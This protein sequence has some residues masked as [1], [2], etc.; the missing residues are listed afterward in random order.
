[1]VP[2]DADKDACACCSEPKP[3][4]KPSQKSE[5]TASKLNDVGSITSSGFKFGATPSTDSS[6]SG[7]T[8]G[9]SGTTSSG[10]TLGTKAETTTPVTKSNDDKKEYS[11]EYLSHLKA[12]NTQ[13]CQWIKTHVEKNPYVFLTPVFKDYEK[14]LKDLEERNQNDNVA[15]PSTTPNKP[16]LGGVFASSKTEKTPPPPVQFGSGSGG[17]AFGAGNV[18]TSAAASAT[19]GSSGG[20]GFTFGKSDDEPDKSLK[21]T[22]FSFGTST[23]T[24]STTS[25]T[26]SFSFGS[27]SSESSGF[28]FGS[29]PAAAAATTG[30]SFGSSSSSGFSFGSSVA[31]ASSAGS[32]E[33]KNAQDEEETNDEPPKVEVKEVV[34]EDAFH[35]VR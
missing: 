10:F 24:A 13:V 8:F 6:S 32:A 17:F 4:A 14:H 3:G 15:S 7:F 18:A 35:S 26:S 1:M 30:F 31:P 9:S 22:G 20:S 12:L 5:G 29:K 27:K 25:T 2:N 28:S 34:E 23:T 16:L 11:K 19:F 33:A 21:N